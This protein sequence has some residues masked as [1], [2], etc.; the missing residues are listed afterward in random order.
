MTKK[1]STKTR[2]KK[3]MAQTADR[4]ELYQ[5]SVQHPDH[6]VEFFEQVFRDEYKRKPLTLREDFCGTFAVCCEWV[7]SGKKRTAM[8]VDLCP[9]TLRWGKDHNLNE[10]KKS[11]L[12]FAMCSMGV[13]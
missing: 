1:S 4:F 11:Q 13:P 2:K 7:K 8:G 9:E 5:K 3:T 6:E 10:L 12:I